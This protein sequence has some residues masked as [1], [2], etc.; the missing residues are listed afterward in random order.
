VLG[1][2]GDTRRLLLL[3]AASGSEE[4]R[5]WSELGELGEVPPAARR[6][7]VDAGLIGDSDAV[8][9]RHPLVRSAAYNASP[10]AERA[11]AHRLLA[12]SASDPLS[13]AS[14]L[15]AAAQ[16]PD[17]ALAAELEEAAATAA[18]RGA[19]ASA[20]SVY[21]RAAAMSTQAEARVRRLIAA[22]HAYLD[23][24]ESDPAARLAEEAL[25]EAS[26]VSDQAA[27]AAVKGALELQRGTPTAAY[28]LL[29]GAARAVAQDDPVRALELQAQAMTASIVAG[30][31]ERAFA[32]A[33]EFIKDLPATDTRYERFLRL[34]LAAIARSDAAAADAAREQLLE[35]LRM[36]AGAEDFRFSM[37]AALASSLLGDLRTGRELSV[38]AVASARAAG[39]FNALPVALL[40]RARLAVVTRSFGEAEEFAQEGVELTRQL[41]QENLE[42][43]F[44]GMLVRCLAVRGR[45]EQ[46][47]ELAEA[48]L[49]RAL[50]HGVA[51]AAADVHVG[52]AELELSL[53]HGAAARELLEAVSHPLFKL[54]ATPYLVE[55]SL[56]CDQAEP[57]RAW[58]DALIDSAEQPDDPQLLGLV[59][60]KRLRD[61]EFLGLL[62]RARAQLAP[63]AEI[64]GRLFLEALRYQGEH[65]QPFELARTQL[66]YGEFLRRA[67]RRTEARVQLRDALAAFEGL[68]TPLWADRARAELE[69]TGITARKRDPSTLDTLTPQELRIAKLVASGASNRDVAGQ[70]FLSP[71][72]VEYHLRKVYM[73]LG[74]S[75][76]V[77]LARQPLAPAVVGPT[78]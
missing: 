76:R 64:A 20:A 18:G 26:T 38:R 72:T 62:A 57:E 60:S 21:S 29:F 58:L 66:A 27:L 68:N 24:G 8:S 15:A 40:A 53:A 73:K 23:A 4:A 39:S 71:K 42:T 19:F 9:F 28:E 54:F 10:Q 34:F 61:P 33:Y 17:E 43:C 69:A 30:S 51:V 22:A 36:G 35:L 56:L 32:D 41:A 1:L 49:R 13:R 14:H 31:A 6:P 25:A 75:S 65:P 37:S 5:T 70:L 45:V 67:Q 3:A 63:S 52:L 46:C 50:A 2:P 47:R 59:A 44:S 16:Q 77:E 11:Q 74:V 55:A 7:A 78:D 12:A 48:T